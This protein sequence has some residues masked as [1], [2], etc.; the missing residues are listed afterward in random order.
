MQC[1]SKSFSCWCFSDDAFQVGLFSDEEETG[2]E[3]YERC[4]YFGIE[5]PE[6]LELRMN[7]PMALQSL[8]GFYF[9]LL[10]DA[11]CS[12]SE[13][14][15]PVFINEHSPSIFPPWFSLLC[16]QMHKIVIK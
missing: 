10:Q 13:F 3:S 7:M 14:R 11:G 5:A 8:L 4:G 9:A 16:I 1:P 12:L 6:A 2:N 15:N